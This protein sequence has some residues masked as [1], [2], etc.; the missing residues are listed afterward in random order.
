MTRDYLDS[1][2]H[3]R[4]AGCGDWKGYNDILVLKAISI[5]LVPA[6]T[7]QTSVQML[8]EVVRREEPQER[9]R[10]SALLEKDEDQY[11]RKLGQRPVSSSHVHIHLSTH[12]LHA[13]R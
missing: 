11:L 6:A 7:G 8:E 13:R 12:P 3:D 4:G 2:M 9:V 1:L 10:K 5:N